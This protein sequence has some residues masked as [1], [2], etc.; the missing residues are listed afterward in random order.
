MKITNYTDENTAN[1]YNFK[2]GKYATFYNT[3]VNEKKIDWKMFFV[4]KDVFGRLARNNSE[5][6]TQNYE[7]D[8]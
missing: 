5:G 7:F 2:I 1:L 6:S 3:T 8:D 4:E